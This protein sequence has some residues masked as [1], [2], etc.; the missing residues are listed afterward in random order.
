MKKVCLCLFIII[1]VPVFAEVYSFP[2]V[3]QNVCG[4]EQQEKIYAIAVNPQTAKLRQIPNVVNL[5]SRQIKEQCPNFSLE[6]F[7]NPK[8]TLDFIVLLTIYDGDH[9]ITALD[10]NYLS[11]LFGE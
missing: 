3:M 1:S 8:R 7:P 9:V 11:Y 6:V 2:P 5:A 4:E 10:M